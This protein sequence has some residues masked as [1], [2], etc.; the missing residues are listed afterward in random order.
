VALIWDIRCY[1]SEDGTDKIREWYD[2]QR[3]QVQSKF[4]S[5]LRTLSNSPLDN[6]GYPLSRSLHGD[7]V[8]LIEIRF[9]VGK[10]A[11]RP[12]GFRGPSQVYTLT[13]CATEKSD[14]FVPRNACTIALQ[15]MKEIERD[16]KR[17]QR[18]WL[19]LE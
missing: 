7:A 18:C 1:V 15:R 16:D 19:P 12:L 9:E 3:R 14:R 17:S 6:W 13:F 2:S 8:P 4:F 10:I 11:Y 5:R